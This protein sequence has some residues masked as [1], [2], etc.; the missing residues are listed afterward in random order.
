MPVGNRAMYLYFKY[1]WNRNHRYQYNTAQVITGDPGVGKTKWAV[2]QSYVL[3]KRR[4]DEN[5]YMNRAQEF[6]QWV[7]DS[8]GGDTGVWDECGVSLSSRRWHSLSNILTA[9]ILQTYRAKKL[10][11]FFVVPDI[12]FIDVQAR[13][14]MTTYCELKR[15]GTTQTTNWLYRISINR[16]SG[17]MYFVSFRMMMEGVLQKVPRLD[18]PGKILKA[19]PKTIWSAIDEKEMAFKDNIRRKSLATLNLID[20]DEMTS[21]ETVYDMIDKVVKDK[22]RFTN[23]KG[24]LDSLLIATILGVSQT[25]ALQVKKFVEKKAD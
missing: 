5:S 22:E 21:S 8:R 6:L 10:T 16:K 23:T 4:F 9:E 2:L 15:Y 24:R 18:I 7:D 11:V 12:S 20:K 1:L 25:K 17:D 14:L 19:V 13:K 3:N